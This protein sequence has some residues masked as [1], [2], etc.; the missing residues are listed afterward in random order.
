MHA[1][2]QDDRDGDV[3]RV[4]SL[5]ERDD[6]VERIVRSIGQPGEHPIVAAMGL[7]KRAS[8]ARIGAALVRVEVFARRAAEL[9]DA[10]IRGALGVAELDRAGRPVDGNARI[11]EF[12]RNAL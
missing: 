4:A 7:G 3:M 9:P 6:D 5:A 2:R 1:I 12:E 8:P 11:P 10:G